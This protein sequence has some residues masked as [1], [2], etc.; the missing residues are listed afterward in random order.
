MVRSLNFEAL[1]PLVYL[2]L[3]RASA[4][5]AVEYFVLVAGNTRTISRTSFTSSAPT[6][7]I[8]VIL[9]KSARESHTLHFAKLLWQDSTGFASDFRLCSAF[10][11]ISSDALSSNVSF[12]LPLSAWNFARVFFS[13]IHSA[14]TVGDR[15]NFLTLDLHLLSVDGNSRPFQSNRFRY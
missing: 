3:P 11:F 4:L 9:S 8:F 2:H 1:H 5:Y 13:S 6:P 10:D 7:R 15:S 12:N 14:N